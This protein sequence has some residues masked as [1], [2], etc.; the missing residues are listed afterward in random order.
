MGVSV[1]TEG[2]TSLAGLP[3]SWLIG[4]HIESIC[5]YSLPL[6]SMDAGFSWGVA[7]SVVRLLSF[8]AQVEEKWKEGYGWVVLFSRLGI[9]QTLHIMLWAF[10][11]RCFCPGT[12]ICLLPALAWWQGASACWGCMALLSLL[13]LYRVSDR[14]LGGCFVVTDDMY[15][16]Q[17]EN[18]ENPLRCPIKLYDF[19]LFKWWEPL[20][21]CTVACLLWLLSCIL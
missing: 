19:Y 16:E 10:I 4:T 3:L 6:K 9:N 2:E 17:T 5:K 11:T 7:V 20:F 8:W 13:Y 21:V 18:P 15:A 12:A 1:W 14:L